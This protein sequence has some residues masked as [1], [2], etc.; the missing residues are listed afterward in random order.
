V[1]HFE[2]EIV[3]EAQSVLAEKQ[4][5]FDSGREGID[6][7]LTARKDYYDVVRQYREALFRHRRAML[8]LNTAVGQRLLP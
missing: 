5:L 1:E 4:R 7:L 6:V 3:P 2:H 8:H